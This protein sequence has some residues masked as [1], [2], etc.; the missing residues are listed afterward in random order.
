MV[1]GSPTSVWISSGHPAIFPSP[2][3]VN[4]YAPAI[5]AYSLN[6][7]ITRAFYARGD[8]VTPMKVAIGMVGLNLSLNLIISRWM[9]RDDLMAR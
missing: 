9:A 6:H 2:A 4:E 3:K 1:A 5:W 8:T 7:T